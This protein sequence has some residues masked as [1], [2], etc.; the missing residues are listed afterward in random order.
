MC[1]SSLFSL[2]DTAVQPAKAGNIKFA[3]VC[4]CGLRGDVRLMC[5]VLIPICL[6]AAAALGLVAASLYTTYSHPVAC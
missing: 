1:G 4:A 3:A 5:Q 6:C 2:L